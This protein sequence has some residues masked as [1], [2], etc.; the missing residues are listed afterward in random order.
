[1][2]LLTDTRPVRLDRRG[3]AIALAVLVAVLAVALAFDRPISQ[4]LTSL[5]I[6]VRR[7]FSV[8]TDL[9]L[10]DWIL[11]PS[12]LLTVV[13][14]VLAITQHRRIVRLAFLQAM[15]VSAFIF[16]GVGAPGLISNLVKR[17]IGRGRPE[18][19]DSV[20]TL[21]FQH[22]LN[23]Y[24][25]QSFPSGHATTSVAAAWVLAFLWPRTWP[26]AV[27]VAGL[28]ALSRVV[29]GAHYATDVIGGIVLGTIG[30]HLV[31]TVFASR[32]WL[33]ER[34]PDGSVVRRP[35]V[36]IRRASRRRPPRP[37]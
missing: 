23:D 8:I 16:V 28:V 34:L 35:F 24:S 12:L 20:G 19:Y 6:G 15:T 21:G 7:F 27:A 37:S 11:I 30:A 2:T 5:P 25:Y 32:R 17:A 36:A 33:F 18:L 26:Y 3:I 9:G 4:A 29:V 14:A 10:S 31:R 13:L 22:F 1:M